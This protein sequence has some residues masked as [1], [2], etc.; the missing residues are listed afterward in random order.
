M[1]GA[2]ASALQGHAVL[3]YLVWGFPIALVIATL[4]THFRLSSTPAE[5]HFRPGQ[6][7]LRSIQDVLAR[8]PVEWRPLH[9]VRQGPEYVEISIGWNTQVL[10][11]PDWPNYLE[12]RSTS[13]A[14]L[15][16]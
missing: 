2:T 11:A 16:R 5:V 3:G 4:W 10:M 15:D 14:A 6:V 7:A 12:L 9:N 1:I 8:R 13:K